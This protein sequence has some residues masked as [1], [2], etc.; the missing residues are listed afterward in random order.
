MTRWL[1]AFS[2]CV[3]CS[4][5]A[6]ASAQP[7]P[8]GPPTLGS[9]RLRAAPKLAGTDGPALVAWRD[10]LLSLYR[11]SSLAPFEVRGAVVPDRGTSYSAELGRDVGNYRIKVDGKGLRGIEL[12]GVELPGNVE[13][14]GD[15]LAPLRELRVWPIRN[16]GQVV[17]GC[18]VEIVR[19]VRA[20]LCLDLAGVDRAAPSVV[21]TELRLMVQCP[22]SQK[23]ED[24]AIVWVSPSA[25]AALSPVTS[26]PSVNA[27][28]SFDT[29]DAARELVC[30]DERA[31]CASLS[32]E[33]TFV[34]AK[35]DVAQPVQ[36]SDLAGFSLK[37]T[38]SRW[39]GVEHKP[40]GLRVVRSAI[41]T[42]HGLPPA[43]RV[44][45]FLAGGDCL[46]WQLQP[47]AV[48]KYP[49]HV[50]VS[51]LC[52]A[53]GAWVDGM[54][55]VTTLRGATHQILQSPVLDDTFTRCAYTQ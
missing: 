12:T 34:I 27:G 52:L 10:A 15:W 41:G 22:P 44:R 23:L 37:G 25:P 1:A 31:W 9:S 55:S 48:R 39:I 16:D 20:E 2:L 50:D 5:A 40:S 4:C 17:T 13:K 54:Y 14:L 38:T 53:D 35:G 19:A 28:F 11:T 3:V 30:T 33:G 32:N 36:A 29:S 43:S 6:S 47:P 26:E 24:L 21:S 46:L 51:T 7:P 42:Y 8:S 18:H 45:D 49:A